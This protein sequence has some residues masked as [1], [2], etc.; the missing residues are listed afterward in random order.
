M[1]QNTSLF[2]LP[3]EIRLAIAGHLD[4]KSLLA[5]SFTCSLFHRLIQFTSEQR[6]QILLRIELLD[7]YGGKMGI[8]GHRPEMGGERFATG[9]QIADWGRF[10]WACS[11]C[12]RLLPH[13]EF[14]NRF[15]FGKSYQKP[16][17]TRPCD[18]VWS[19]D[20]RPDEDGADAE[21]NVGRRLPGSGGQ[22]H[23][24]QCNECLY[25]RN[26]SALR[27]VDEFCLRSTVITSPALSRR[28]PVVN[29]RRIRCASAVNRF[30]PGFLDFLSQSLD[31]SKDVPSTRAV[32][33]LGYHSTL[34][35]VPS[36]KCYMLRCPGCER[37]KE[38]R[39]FPLP[40][41]VSYW[42]FDAESTK[43]RLF[44]SSYRLLQFDEHHPITFGCIACLNTKE[45][46]HRAISEVA[47]TLFRSEID[48][49]IKAEELRLQIGW[50]VMTE[51]IKS[52]WPESVRQELETVEGILYNSRQ[53]GTGLDMQ[54][55]GK[56][57]GKLRDFMNEVSRDASFQRNCCSQTCPRSK[58]AAF[59]KYYDVL[60]E[61][62]RW[63][64]EAKAAVEAMP[65]LFINWALDPQNM[66]RPPW[67]QPDL[68]VRK[69][70]SS[71]SE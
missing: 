34:Y 62:V 53:E 26:S 22:R 60:E 8:Y 44:V 36:F 50:Q 4:A 39:S 55:L 27:Y 19:W 58:V 71:E 28:I 48:N 67:D 35:N 6:L 59:V 21:K 57:R 64:H 54:Q 43:E 20:S 61:E 51:F 11:G 42:G 30:F 24:R 33:Y 29:S 70:S 7:R 13:L 52:E 17:P 10:R 69:Y 32:K 46:E 12:L 3:A 41:N 56:S 37:W 65:E 68:P 16:V 15:I 31:A 38:L 2:S 18:R 1:A 66:D 47:L 63:L 45:N 40:C 23:L 49:A 5:L 25:Q 9:Q 14:D